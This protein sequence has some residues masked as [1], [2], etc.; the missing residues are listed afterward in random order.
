MR[1][2]PS[3]RSG[4]AVSLERGFDGAR[5]GQTPFDQLRPDGRREAPTIPSLA[6][7]LKR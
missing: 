4:E 1:D 3:G 6:A 7:Q 2:T 5:A